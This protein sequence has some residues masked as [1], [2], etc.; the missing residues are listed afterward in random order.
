MIAAWQRAETTHRRAEDLG[1]AVDLILRSV[2]SIDDLVRLLESA[3][4]SVR[5]VKALRA[6]LAMRRGRR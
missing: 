2:P 4:G 3:G 1:I 6:E 5:L